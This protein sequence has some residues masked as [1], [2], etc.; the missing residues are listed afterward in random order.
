M[1]KNLA[2]V[3]IG[4]SC[5]MAS[6]ASRGQTTPGSPLPSRDSSCVAALDSMAAVFQRDYPG[7]RDKVPGN[8]D[9][10]ASLVDSV[11]TVARTSDHYSICIPAL[12]RYARFFRDPHIAGPWQAAPPV[13]PASGAGSSASS[14]GSLGRDDPRLPTVHSVDSSAAIIRVP[15]FDVRYK[16]AIDSLIIA[17]SRLL[18]SRPFLIIDVRGNGGGCS[19]SYLGILPLLYSQPFH[20]AGGDVLA[21]AANAAYYRRLLTGDLPEADK[22][23]IRSA[24][25]RM[26][27][28]PGEFV[29]LSPDRTVQLDS[30]LPIPR[31]VAVLVDGGCA[32][33]CEGFVSDARQSTKVTVFGTENTRGAADYGN[34]RAVLLPGWRE[35]RMPT[36]RSRGTRIDNIGLEPTVKIPKGE[37]DV[38]GFV[39]R[40]LAG[41]S[42]G[43]Q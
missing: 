33:S 28:H 19:C 13:P 17:N 1:R 35:M 27:A 30:V 36:S 5:L 10:L 9:A 26:D 6:G 15:D 40:F 39:R 22:E 2:G 38:I 24:L 29:E 32:S 4:A 8:E 41:S 34:I 12:Q 23:R 42:T 21:S 25:A 3:F 31:K 7:Y 37:P 18:L 16:R 11:R 43:S 14:P 20:V